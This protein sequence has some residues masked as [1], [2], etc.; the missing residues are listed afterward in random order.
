M[1]KGGYQIIDLEGRN[2]TD[3]VGMVYDGIY[4]TIESTPKTYLISGLVVEDIDYNDEF[5]TPTVD[6][7]NY[8]FHLLNNTITLTVTD[9]DV[10]TVALE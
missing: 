9:T 7:S 6:G 8:V 4:D 3:G 2:L 10:V 1:K 5:A